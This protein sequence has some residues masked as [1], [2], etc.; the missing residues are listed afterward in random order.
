MIPKVKNYK[1]IL[2]GNSV[3]NVIN[4]NHSFIK[5]HNNYDNN[6]ISF[7]YEE[8]FYNTDNIIYFEKYEIIDIYNYYNFTICKILYKNKIY[9]IMKEKHNNIMGYMEINHSDFKTVKDI[10]FYPEYQRQ[11][12]L[13]TLVY[14]IVKIQRLFFNMDNI[15]H[16]NFIR[17]LKKN[18]FI[19]SIREENNNHISLYHDTNKRYLEIDYYMKSIMYKR[20]TMFGHELYNEGY[21][22]WTP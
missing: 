3:K 14:G 7:P 22:Y 8:T 20:L 11:G 2:L 19:L 21:E 6:H 5:I 9:Y 17:L 10:Y 13:K 16:K 4:N 12:Y 1:E 18:L 15:D